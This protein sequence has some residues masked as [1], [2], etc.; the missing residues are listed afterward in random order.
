MKF[1]ALVGDLVVRWKPTKT[2]VA[3]IQKAVTI[4]RSEV[5]VKDGNTVCGG[6][7]ALLTVVQK[8]E[9]DRRMPKLNEE[10]ENDWALIRGWLGTIA[11]N[12]AK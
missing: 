5:A 6:L 4:L 10:Q 3:N 9:E 1:H 12:I 7:L 2:S 11:Y 8:M